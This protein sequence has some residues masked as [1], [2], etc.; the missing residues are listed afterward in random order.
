MRERTAVLVAWHR[1]RKQ[2]FRYPMPQQ[3]EKVSISVLLLTICHCC[4]T[5]R[6]P[7]DKRDTTER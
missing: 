6:Q 5:D 2:L 1:E 7:T 4:S 3:C